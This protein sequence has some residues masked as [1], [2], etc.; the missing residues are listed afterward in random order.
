MRKILRLNIKFFFG[1]T[2]RIY[3][4]N[5]NRLLL[6]VSP[7]KRYLFEFKINVSEIDTVYFL[8]I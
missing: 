5:L 4:V 3:L 2:I 6:Y 1:G 7:V 8:A